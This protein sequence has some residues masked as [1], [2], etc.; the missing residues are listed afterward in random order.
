MR[1]HNDN[2]RLKAVLVRK[3]KRMN[4]GQPIYPQPR[5]SRRLTIS[6]EG[7]DIFA[8]DLQPIGHCTQWLATFPNKLQIIDGQTAIYN[9]VKK[10]MPPRLGINNF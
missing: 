3:Q 1:K 10:Q 4:E 2:D 9:E 5:K 6:E 8:V 7:V